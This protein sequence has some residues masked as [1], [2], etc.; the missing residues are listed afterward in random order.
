MKDIENIKCYILE[1]T[2]KYDD[3]LEIY[4]RLDNIYRMLKRL[5]E[6]DSRFANISFIMGISNT[7]S[8][9]VNVGYLHTGKRGRPK[10]E[11]TGVKIKWH[12]HIYVASPTDMV[13]TFCECA[14]RK[15]RKNYKIYKWDRGNSEGIEKYMEQ[16]E[17]TRHHGNY[18]NFRNKKKKIK[19]NPVK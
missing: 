19:N 2:N 3:Y 5:A 17:N 8:S 11:I 4:Q 15:L 9:T 12:F 16:C 6:S 14:I 1:I 18:F 7:K 13:A 10:K